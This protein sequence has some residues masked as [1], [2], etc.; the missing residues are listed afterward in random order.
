MGDNG[1]SNIGGFQ[2]LH[3]NDWPPLGFAHLTV[4]ADLNVIPAA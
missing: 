2:F 3:D 4:T 1:V